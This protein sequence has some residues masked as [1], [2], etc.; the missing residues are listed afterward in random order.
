MSQTD[1][2]SGIVGFLLTLMVFSYILGDNP[3]FRIATYLFVGVTAGFVLVT[4]I[5]QVIIPLLFLPLLTGALISRAIALIPLLLSI[6][7]LLK[8][9]PSLA[10]LGN[11]SMAYLVGAGAAIMIGGAVLGTIIPQITGTINLF[12]LNAAASNPNGA[13]FQLIDG[14][15]VVV[16]FLTAMMFFYFGAQN[17]PNKPIQ[18][19]PVIEKMAQVGQVFIGI[20]LGSLFAGVY[21]SAFSALIDRVSSLWNFIHLLFG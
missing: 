18:R 8:I 1:L 13:G 17:S 19:G 14:I 9:F 4:V 15:L 10:R 3:A 16:G 12:D 7:M 2:I 20:T 5:S 11:V 21:S 6:F